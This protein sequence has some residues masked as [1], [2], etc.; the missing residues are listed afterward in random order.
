VRGELDLTNAS[1]LDEALLQTSARA[2]ILDLGGLDF[3]D[4]AG[5]R[6]IDRAH[7][8]LADDG[9]MLL[10]VAPGDSRAGWTFRVAGFANGTVLESVEIARRRAAGRRAAP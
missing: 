5:M 2:V 8:R 10:I 1:A 3:V 4:S 9:R 6:A 7:R